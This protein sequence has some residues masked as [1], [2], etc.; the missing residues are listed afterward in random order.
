MN[1]TLLSR[2]ISATCDDCLYE[3]LD[4]A[5]RRYLYPFI[6]CTNCGPRFTIVQD[7][8]Y[9]RSK[10]TVEFS[11]SARFVSENTKIRSIDAFMLSPMPAQ[12]VARNYNYYGG[13]DAIHLSPENGFPDLQTQYR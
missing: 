10:T 6:N 2:P 9:D 12:T 4:P 3:L 7:V 5:D 11:R 8:P 13:R 1:D